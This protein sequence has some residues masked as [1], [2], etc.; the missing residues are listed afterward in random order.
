M[1]FTFRHERG[2]IRVDGSI[3]GLEKDAL[4]QLY[5]DTG[6]EQTVINTELMKEIG[7][8]PEKESE[9][10]ELITG[11]GK[12]LASLLVLPK[13]YALGKLKENFP[14]F[15]HSLPTTANIDGVLGLDFLRANVL[16]ID[17]INGQIT[18]E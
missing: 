17:F 3:L 9:L 12:V 8:K 14:V 11:S 15:C 2:L 1:S 10:H 16:K 7:Y 6:A 13:I 18:F 5:F 4:V